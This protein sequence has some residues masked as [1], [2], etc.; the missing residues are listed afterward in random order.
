MLSRLEPAALVQ[1]AATVVQRLVV[2]TLSHDHEL[3]GLENCTS[4]MVVSSSRPLPTTAVAATGALPV[5]HLEPD[6]EAPPPPPRGA[7]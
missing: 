4:G 5:V 7:P 3:D 1:H 6:A 2:Q